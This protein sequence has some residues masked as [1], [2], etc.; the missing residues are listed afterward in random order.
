MKY[1]NILIVIFLFMCCCDFTSELENVEVEEMHDYY[2]ENDIKIE[3]IEDALC[4]VYSE[5]EYKRDT[6]VRDDWQLPEETL[7]I[8]SGDCEDFAI[9]FQYLV[10]TKL[11]IKTY[12]I[13]VYRLDTQTIHS[14]VE[15]NG[16]YYEVTSNFKYYNFP[17]NTNIIYK[18]PYSETIWM[19][20]HYGEN[21]GRYY[22]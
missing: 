19:T 3:S 7:R 21:V 6:T 8:K 5:I 11:N 20:Y 9:L 14:I 4:F 18:I 12:T 16:F 15:I 13:L 22:F 1:F 2:F 10:E 17:K